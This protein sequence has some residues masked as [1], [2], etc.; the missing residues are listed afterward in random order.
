[1]YDV[2]FIQM[3]TENNMECI[4]GLKDEEM[5]ESRRQ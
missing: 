5:Q 2:C 3:E 1:M 4:A